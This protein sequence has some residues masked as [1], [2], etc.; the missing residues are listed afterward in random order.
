MRKTPHTWKN[1]S[2]WSKRCEKKPSPHRRTKREENPC[3]VTIPSRLHRPIAP[4]S[5]QQPS[6]FAVFFK[7]RIQKLQ[8]LHPRRRLVGG[9]GSPQMGIH[10]GRSPLCELSCYFFAS[11]KE[12]MPLYQRI[13]NFVRTTLIQQNFALLIRQPSSGC[14]LRWRRLIYAPSRGFACANEPSPHGQANPV[15]RTT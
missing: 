8:Q 1:I 4:P 12:V 14:H 7:R 13:A 9:D 3:P 6:V 15:A 5:R 11:S 2:R 10:K